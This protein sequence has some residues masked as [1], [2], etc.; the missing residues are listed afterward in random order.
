MSIETINRYDTQVFKYGVYHKENQRWLQSLAFYR[1]EI[2]YFKGLIADVKAKNTLPEVINPLYVFEQRIQSVTTESDTLLLL[3]N[4][5][6]WG[7]EDDALG[8]AFLLGEQIYQHH[9]DL[10]ERY[11]AFEREIVKTKHELYRFLAKV[12]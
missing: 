11:D 9:Y 3:V 1:E 6:Q 10:R 12:F 2:S 5:E 7:F 8:K 4:Q